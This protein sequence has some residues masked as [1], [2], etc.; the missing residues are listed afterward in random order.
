MGYVL[1]HG[2]RGL[3]SRCQVK[4][5]LSAEGAADRIKGQ[6]GFVAIWRSKR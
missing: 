2:D 5:Q 1:S 3:R 6:L 4:R